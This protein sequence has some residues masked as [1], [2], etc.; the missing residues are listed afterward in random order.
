MQSTMT[1][2]HALAALSAFVILT[3]VAIR[4][5]C[6]LPQYFLIL[7]IFLFLTLLPIRFLVKVQP[8]K[9]R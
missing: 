7:T 4:T 6:S 1:F 9:K 5:N 2:Q 8:P 3:A